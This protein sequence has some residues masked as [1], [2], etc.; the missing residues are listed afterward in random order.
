MI[1]FEK[2]LKISL[3]DSNESC[4]RKPTSDNQ[5]HS[6]VIAFRRLC[7]SAIAIAADLL[8]HKLIQ[9]FPWATINEGEDLLLFD[10]DSD[11]F[12][13]NVLC[14]SLYTHNVHITQSTLAQSHSLRLP[15]CLAQAC[16]S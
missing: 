16:V 1:W 6:V 14:H 2:A 8:L 7:A 12:E 10:E 4:W 13:K 3:F 15:T 11:L 9:S 5:F